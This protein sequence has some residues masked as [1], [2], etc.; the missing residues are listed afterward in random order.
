MCFG[1][2][3]VCWTLDRKICPLPGDRAVW[4]DVDVFIPTYNESLD[5]I[6]PTVFAALNLDWPKEKLHV[7]I[8]DD[9]SR[10]AFRQFADE[11]GAGYIKREERRRATSITL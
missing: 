9:G 5:V 7:H 1:Y 3:Q 4:P 2:F 6:K 11:V 8:L 10:D